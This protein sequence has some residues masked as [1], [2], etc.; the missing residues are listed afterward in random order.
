MNF[1]HVIIRFG[2]LSLK[3]K[4]RHQFIDKLYENTKTKLRECE[5]VRLRR[6]FDRMYVELNG[7]PYLPVIR[8][9]QDV[10]GIQTLSVAMRVPSDLENIQQGALAAVNE[11]DGAHTF[12]VSAKR[13]DK[14]FPVH[15]QN[16]NRRIGGYVLQNGNGLKVDVHHPD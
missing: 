4:N 13:I 9:L 10:F 16:L 14:N 11:V 6:S 2:E 12:K 3:G 15:S 8:K 7:K 5:Q 1:D